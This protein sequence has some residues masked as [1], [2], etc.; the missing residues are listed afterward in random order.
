MDRAA[1]HE[2]RRNT[3]NGDSH[4]RWYPTPRREPRST[5]SKAADAVQIGADLSTFSA[6]GQRR[7]AR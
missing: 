7:A 4:E 2:V 6:T 3:R 1:P 5:R